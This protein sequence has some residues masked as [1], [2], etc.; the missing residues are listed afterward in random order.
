MSPSPVI[1]IKKKR[2]ESFLTIISPITYRPADSDLSLGLIGHFKFL[3][4]I[5]FTSNPYLRLIDHV[6]PLFKV[7]FT[8]SHFLRKCIHCG[9]LNEF[10]S[11]QMSSRHFFFP[12]VHYNVD[13]LVDR[14]HDQCYGLWL[15]PSAWIV[16]M[17]YI[18]R[19]SL[20]KY[21]N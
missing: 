13:A 7:K 1:V 17:K 10:S 8:L 14:G 6:R 18:Y 15:W 3:F 19:Y 9:S 2:K 16:A 5:T 12:T 21:I 11:N 20:I 4:E